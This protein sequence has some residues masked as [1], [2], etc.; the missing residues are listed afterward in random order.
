MQT[1]QITLSANAGISLEM[2]GKRILVDP[3]HTEKQ[4][5]FSTVR[6]SLF[7][8]ILNEPSFAKPDCICYT[9]CH[10]DHFSRELTEAYLRKWPNAELF[11]PEPVFDRQHLVSEPV[12]TWEKNDICLQFLRLPHEGAIY[13]DT[14]HYGL[15]VKIAGVHILIPGD[16]AVASPVLAERL[17]GEKIHLAILDFPWITLKRGR[18]FVLQILK[19]ESVVAFHLPFEE[20]DVCGY[21]DA[22]CRAADSLPLPVKMLAEP[23]QKEFITIKGVL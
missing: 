14:V 5:G 15:L 12:F 13:R 9:H 4:Q 1:I 8:E 2:G 11:L 17:K 3:F 21:R 7:G 22:V 10:P 19:P 16:C 18:E 6:P 23:M 20:D